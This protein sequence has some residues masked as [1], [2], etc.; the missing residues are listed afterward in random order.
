MGWQKRSSVQCNVNLFLLKNKKKKWILGWRRMSLLSIISLCDSLAR[1]LLKTKEQGEISISATPVLISLQTL[2]RLRVM[3]T[4]RSRPGLFGLAVIF[5]LALAPVA[6][7]GEKSKPGKEKKIEAR[8]QP[9]QIRKVLSSD[10]PLLYSGNSMDD[11]LNFLKNRTGVTFEMDRQMLEM[12]GLA[13]FPQA[14]GVNIDLK[15]EKG[16]VGRGLQQFL[17]K[18]RM[19]YYIAGDRV[20]ITAS[21]L[22]LARTM[23]Q[24]VEVDF[25]NVTLA[26]AL[27]KL[28]SATGT[29]I[30]LDSTLPLDHLKPFTMQ[31]GEA[32]L[33]E[34]VRLVAFMGGMKSVRV[35]KIII[36]TSPEKAKLLPAEQPLHGQQLFEAPLIQQFPGMGIPGM[37][38]PGGGVGGFGGVFPQPPMDIPVPQQ[39]DVAPAPE[40]APDRPVEAP[41][42]A[43]AVPPQPD[44]NPRPAPLPRG[45]PN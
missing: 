5:A 6:L 30:F 26:G 44:V 19:D 28:E 17:S 18:Y 22:A 16:K 7:G 31:V 20:V 24:P 13:V 27:K 1:F 29:T 8:T 39:A 34:A 38:F 35:G 15:I 9:D 11:I 21:Q 2:W 41:A 10:M 33:D 37:A 14:P 3:K 32:P 12:Y 45:L 42:G 23:R 40:P 36:V 25:Q 43:P 4:T